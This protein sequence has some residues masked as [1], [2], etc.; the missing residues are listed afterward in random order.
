MLRKDPIGDPILLLYVTSLL[1]LSFSSSTASSISHL[2]SSIVCSQFFDIFLFLFL[3]M[4]CRPDGTTFKA[5]SQGLPLRAGDIVTFSYESY[6]PRSLPV[7]PLVTRVRLDKFWR[8]IV[9]EFR[10]S[11][12]QNYNGK[13]PLLLMLSFCFCYFFVANFSNLGV[14][15][16]YLPLSPKPAGYWLSDQRRNMR[17]V[18][19]KFARSRNFEP[20]VAKNWY[21]ISKLM[22]RQDKV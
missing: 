17:E 7:N 9:R 20:L 12:Q 21:P 14:D 11:Q 13:L 10:E 6:S 19:E 5:Q 1:Y 15:Q 16:K 4:S 18:F 8:E 22:F 3:F 2:L